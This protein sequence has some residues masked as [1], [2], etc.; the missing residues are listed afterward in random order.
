[1]SP[2]QLF[3]MRGLPNDDRLVRLG[4][5]ETITGKP[6]RFDCRIC[7]A[8]FVDMR[9]RD[10]HGFARHEVSDTIEYREPQASDVAGIDE[11]SFVGSQ[12]DND[13]A[14]GKDA[15]PLYLDRTAANLGVKPDAPI[16][17]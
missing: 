5:V 10:A 14:E 2:G 17:L 6:E 3:R 4:F 7:G 9:T 8:S 12:P 1:M 11:N 13:P 16:S 15:P